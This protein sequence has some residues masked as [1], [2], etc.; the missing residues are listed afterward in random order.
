MVNKCIIHSSWDMKDTIPLSLTNVYEANILTDLVDDTEYAVFVRTLTA[1][2]REA[3]SP[4]LYFTTSITGEVG[5]EILYTSK[6][7]TYE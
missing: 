7:S 6:T 2:G 4:I 5:K 1:D 3:S